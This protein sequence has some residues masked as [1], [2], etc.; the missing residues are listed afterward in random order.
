[1]LRA[2]EGLGGLMDDLMIWH[3]E[4]ASRWLE[5]VRGLARRLETIEG[6]AEAARELADG[7]RSALIDGMP[8]APGHGSDKVSEAV[9]RMNA[10]QA[11]LEDAAVELMD[12][13]RDARERLARLED[14]DHEAVLVGRYVNGWSWKRCCDEL[15]YSWSGLMDLRRRALAEAWNIMPLEWRE[16]SHGGAA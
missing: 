10:A 5:H 14:A 11:A 9:A 1:M 4:Q 16:P 2:A 12:A 7:L 3:A 13:R 8:K 6:E 15:S